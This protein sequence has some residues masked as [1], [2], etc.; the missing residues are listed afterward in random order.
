MT[1]ASPRYCYHADE[2]FYSR[3]KGYQVVRITEGESG[4]ATTGVA[5]FDLA[6]AE[7]VAKLRNDRLGL[8]DK[9]VMDIRTSSMMQHWREHP[10]VDDEEDPTP[11]YQIVVSDM[12]GT[13]I[14]SVEC[15]RADLLREVSNPASVLSGINERR[16]EG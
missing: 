10:P 4:F 12:N 16:L 1:T 11:D 9:D 8:T 2:S 3:E 14:D 13:V 5:F 7:A 6:A 15:T